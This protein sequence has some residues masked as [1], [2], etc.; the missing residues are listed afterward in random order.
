MKDITRAQ[1]N[2]GVLIGACLNITH[3]EWVEKILTEYPDDKIPSELHG[4]LASIIG[5][6]ADPEPTLQSRADY[7]QA[8]A[9]LSD[10]GLEW[11]V[12]NFGEMPELI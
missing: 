6:L 3:A 4:P 5:N 7:L 1:F 9:G 2:R 12:K 8:L 11:L 10:D